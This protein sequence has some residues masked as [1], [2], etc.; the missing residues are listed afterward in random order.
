MAGRPASSTATPSSLRLEV[1]K[2]LQA[3]VED[4]DVRDRLDRGP[5]AEAKGREHWV[6][7]L[8]LRAQE[9]SQAHVDTLIGSAYSNLVARLQSIADRLEKVEALGRTSE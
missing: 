3:I 1:L 2:E 4:R 6:L 5:L 7:H 9:L 8:L